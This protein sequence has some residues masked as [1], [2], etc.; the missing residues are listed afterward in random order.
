MR[1]CIQ[2]GFFAIL[3]SCPIFWGLGDPFE[4]DLNSPFEAKRLLFIL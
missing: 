4:M 1:E 3:F 2:R